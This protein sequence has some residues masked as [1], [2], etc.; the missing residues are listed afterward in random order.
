M[1]DE[2]VLLSAAYEAQIRKVVVAFLG[3]HL[4]LT[5]HA[6]KP[7]E[8]KASRF[9]TT[10]VILDE[11]LP[12]AD[13]LMTDESEEVDEGIPE[14]NA[15]ICRLNKTTML[16]E[17]TEDRLHVYNR[18]AE[19]HEADTPGAAIPVNGHYWFFGDCDPLSDRPTAPWDI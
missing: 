4:D 5:E 9:T 14:P 1:P 12:G 13:F 10:A 11:D 18:S 6:E 16:Y 7:R 15:T 17:Q 8:R 2:A 3:R 19:D